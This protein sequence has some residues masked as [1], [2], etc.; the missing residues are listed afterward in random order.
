MSNYEVIKFVS[1]IKN[2]VKDDEIEFSKIID[3]YT[4]MPNEDTD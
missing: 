1:L 2:I 4:Q 3:F